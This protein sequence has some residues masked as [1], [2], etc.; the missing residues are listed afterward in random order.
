MKSR[1]CYETHTDCNGDTCKYSQGV[2][3]ITRE[4]RNEIQARLD[5]LN[6][7]IDTI[8][9]KRTGWAS[10]KPEE[11][12]ANIPDVTNEER[13]SLEVFDFIDN[14]PE[15]YFL[16]VDVKNK[17]VTTWTGEKLGNITYLSAP[18]RCGFGI[19]TKR[20]SLRFTAINGAV[21]SGFYFT[22]SGDYARVK[23]IKGAA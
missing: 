19:H 7:W 1:I 21:Y 4:Q 11:K 23:M 14:P 8:R 13:S 16:Y 22:S 20:Q 17:I 2:N 9:D 3:I 15:K 10:Y 12:P 6:A 5:K 18:F